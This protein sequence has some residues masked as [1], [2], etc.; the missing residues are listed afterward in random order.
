VPP[1]A[2]RVLDDYRNC[3]LKD[4]MRCAAALFQYDSESQVAKAADT[5]FVVDSLTVVRKRFGRASEFKLYDHP[6]VYA[7]VAVGSADLE[8]WKAHPA[9]TKLTYQTRYSQF[10]DGY[11]A[12]ELCNV[13]SGWAIRSVHFGLPLADPRSASR[14]ASVFK[15]LQQ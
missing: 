14:T 15:E 12:V 11:L 8:Y 13:T 7:E 3:V 2:V 5:Q 10:G 9:S 4:D 1:E 6:T